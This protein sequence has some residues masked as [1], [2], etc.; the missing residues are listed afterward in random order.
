MQKIDA[1]VHYHLDHPDSDAMLDRVEVAC[2]LNVGVPH[3]PT[4]VWQAHSALY[5]RMAAAKPRRYTWC[6]TFDPQGSEQPDYADR[7][8]AGLETD[9]AAGAIACK[10]WKNLG[11]EIR[12]RSGE[13]LM[14][15]DRVFD[16]I[17]AFLAKR[18]VTL[19]AH[20]GEPRACWRP[21]SEPSPHVGYYTANPE[22]HMHGR[23]DIPTHAELIAARDRLLAK[24]PRLRVVGA[25]LGSLEHDVAELAR[26]FDAFPNFFADTSART[27][28][29]AC[30]DVATVRDFFARYADRIL[31][32]S[33][34]V[35]RQQADA[36]TSD[37]L[38]E[39]LKHVEARYRTES[40]YYET[41]GP[42]A[43]QQRTVPGL[44]LPPAILDRFYRRNAQ[45]CYPGIG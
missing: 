1:H 37:G 36:F 42:V 9:L 13:H 30:Q 35:V 16:P 31:F 33:D 14:V 41:A 44:N 29:L 12:K 38:S 34:I 10:V 27:A 23:T 39:H 15:D 3:G 19:L 4:S 32:G 25:H 21:L 26:R 24:F 6:T 5:R 43:I 45:A 18:G 17:Y 2:L 28:D 11:M 8:I 40:A 20:I 22:W 7:V